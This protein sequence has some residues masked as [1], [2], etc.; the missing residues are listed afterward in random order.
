MANRKRIVFRLIVIASCVFAALVFLGPVFL[1]PNRYRPQI[2]SY[3]EESTGKKVEIERLALT[4]FPKPAIHIDGF[5]VKSP[6]LFPPSYVVKVPQADATLDLR[7]LLHG[8]VVITSLV[9]DGP[10]I[11]LISDPD[12]PWNFENPESKNFE[13]PLSPGHHRQGGDS[14]W[15]VD[16]LESAAFRRTRPRLSGGPRHYE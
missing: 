15:P 14:S 16:C 5:G 3:F 13:E 10:E 4:L 12:G 8:K 6:P 7:A 2:I 11:N 1:N 9:L